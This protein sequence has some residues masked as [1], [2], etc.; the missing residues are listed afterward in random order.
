MVVGCLVEKEGKILLARRGIEPRKGF[1]NLPCGFLENEETIEQGAV[2]EV[3]E[4]TGVQL[5]LGGL[6]TVY[7]LPHANQ[8]YLIFKAKMLGDHFELTPEST[9]IAFFSEE[10][11]PWREIAFS[12]N[13]FALKHYFREPAS[14][15]VHLGTFRKNKHE[16]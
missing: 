13:T 2:R 11:V 9:E 1:W 6:H 16:D 5:E 4:E 3:L 12:S 14:A 7:N 10:E 15:E 8:V